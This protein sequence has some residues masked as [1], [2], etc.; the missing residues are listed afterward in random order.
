MSTPSFQ[1]F[2]TR[3]PAVMTIEPRV[4]GD[5]RGCFLES[6]QRDKFA[7]GGV[8]AT[9]VQDNLSESTQGTLRGLHYQIRQPQG[10]LVQVLAGEVFD[11]AVDL[12][13]S[14]PTFGQWVGERLSWQNKRLLWIPP[15]FA[16]GFY[17]LSPTALFAYKC[18]EFYAPEQERTIA[19]NDPD[20]GIA[21][22]LLPDLPPALSPKDRAGVAFRCAEYYP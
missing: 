13:Q 21:W 7:A 9:L 20:L 2:P 22:P 15:G 1:F 3:I 5:H 4:F 6:W 16:H 12:R 18:T 8:E 17:V 14:S 19:W 11:V 10:K